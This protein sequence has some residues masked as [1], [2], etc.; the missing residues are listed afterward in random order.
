MKLF[1]LRLTIISSLVLCILFNAEGQNIR[2]YSNEY[3]AI[4][5]G[6]RAFGMSNAI[7]ASSEGVTAGY[8]NPAG[9][10]DQK[11]KI[12]L[13][14][15]HSNL[16]G[17]VA[18]Y[19][20]LA[21]STRTKNYAALA[22]SM[23]RVGVDGIPN[24]TDLIRNGQINYDRVTSFSAV[25]YA[26]MVSYA[27]R[28]LNDKLSI[29]GTA[30]I[31]R[32][33]GGEF[34]KAN[35]FG[36]DAGVKYRTDSDWFFAANARDI[37]TTF[38]AWQ[39]Q[40][41]KAEEQTFVQTGN[42]IPVNSLEITLPSFILGAAKRFT[43]N[44]EFSL[45]TELN[46]DLTTDGRR[47][48]VLQTDMISVAP[49]FGLEANYSDIIYL[50]GGIGG[51]QEVLDLELAQQWTFQPNIGLG[52]RLKNLIIDYALTDI[53]DNAAAQYSHVFSIST[54]INPSSNN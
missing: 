13:S 39:V 8:W 43:F 10:V 31:I 26:L 3:L 37:T 7:A 35:G 41:T 11:D 12:Q 47:N 44:D 15:M 45:L 24:T 42:D 53:G 23:I 17:S 46:A 38:T 29:G 30:K 32:R 28:L 16:Y 48:T 51:F 54:A 6:A 27:Q 18:N 40:L 1:S 36:I 34:A 25:D 33:L 19:D 49:N 22:F 52:L 9:L 5:V 4:G 20:Y 21:L 14:F 2:K 50:R